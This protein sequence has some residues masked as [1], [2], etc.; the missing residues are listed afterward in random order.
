MNAMYGG[1]LALSGENI[2][3]CCNDLNG[4]ATAFCSRPGGSYGGSLAELG[5][6]CFFCQRPMIH[7]SAEGSLLHIFV[8]TIYSR[9]INIVTVPAIHYRTLDKKIYIF[10]RLGE[11]D[12]S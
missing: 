1:C 7:V 11:T 4:I 8:Q 6:I 5:G 3:P 9:G 2:L 12:R 10:H